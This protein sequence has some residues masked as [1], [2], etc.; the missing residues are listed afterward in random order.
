MK[1]LEDYMK[2]TYRVN[3]IPDPDEGVSMNQLCMYLLSSNLQVLK[4]KKA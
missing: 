4:N 1:T 3:I 2:L